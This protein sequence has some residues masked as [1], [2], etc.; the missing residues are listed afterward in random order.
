[1]QVNGEPFEYTPELTLHAL[2]D[3]LNVKREGVAVAV[4]D[5]IYAGIRVPDVVLQPDDVIDIVR[6]TA[7]G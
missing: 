5:D 1:M 2:L 4:N 3:Q 7:G 6:I